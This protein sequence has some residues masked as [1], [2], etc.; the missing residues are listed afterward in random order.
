MA[1]ERH[2]INQKFT[3]T[4]HFYKSS[5]MRSFKRLKMPLFSSRPYIIPGSMLFLAVSLGAFGAHGLKDY[6]ES[7]PDLKPIFETAVLYQFI[8]GLAALWCSG[9][10]EP[11][12]KVA[13]WIFLAGTILFSG[14][15]YLLV[16]SGIRSFGAITPIGGL[17]FLCGWI[18]VACSKS[19]N[20]EKNQVQQD[21]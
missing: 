21:Q 5:K 12:A 1:V 9:K 17:L 20:L 7:H 16:F 6:F 11:K 4:S 3:A 2:L 13:L 14:S 8:H 10:D 15:L 19:S 18:V